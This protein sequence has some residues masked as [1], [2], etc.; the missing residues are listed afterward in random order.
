[1]NSKMTGILAAVIP[2]LAGIADLFAPQIG[3]FVAAHPSAAIWFTAVSTLV[4]ALGKSIVAPK[5]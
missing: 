4:A 1:M 5:A 3:A 2:V